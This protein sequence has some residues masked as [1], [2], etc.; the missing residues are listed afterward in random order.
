MK[1][2]EVTVE[3]SFPD[4]DM[5]IDRARAAMEQIADASQDRIDEIVKSLA[6]AVYRDDYARNL[7]EMAVCDTGLGNV[8]DKTIKNKRKNYGTLC[9]LMAVQTRGLCEA[10]PERGLYTYY[11]PVGVVGSLTPATNPGATPANQALMALKG[12]NAIIISPSPAAARTARQLKCYFDEALTS[13]GAPI[14]LFQVVD[15]PI[16]LPRAKYLSGAVDLLLVTG[17]QKN[18]RTGYKSGTPCIGVGKGNVPVIIDSSADFADAARKICASKTFD[19]STSCS[20]EN[21]LIILDEVYDEMLNELQIVGGYLATQEEGERISDMLFEDGK[22]NRYAVGQDLDVLDSFFGLD[23]R[24]TGKRFIMVK[25]QIYGLDAPLSGEKLSLIMTIFR[26]KSFDSAM[27]IVD[28]ILAYEGIGHSVGIHT[29]SD[30]NAHRLAARTKVARVLV[31]QA[32][33]FGNGG[34]LDNAL[35]VTLTMGCGTWA[36]NSISEN[37]SIKNF[38]NKTVLV[39]TFDKYIPERSDM[40]GT[41]YDKTLDVG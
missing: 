11:K 17:D 12:G 6:W 10:E 36:G 8:I 1:S 5:M 23:G 40:F 18:V 16:S 31:N 21:A 35:P 24:T 22:V 20:A 28:G 3:V 29:A 2:T 30:S 19:N 15:L 32:H 27:D 41:F 4:I 25:E 37:M 39:K 14:D 13:I 9:D 7:A 26:A 34:G 33:A 38:V